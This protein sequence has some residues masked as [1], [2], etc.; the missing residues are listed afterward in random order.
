MERVPGYAIASFQQD[1]NSP[2]MLLNVNTA[3][4]IRNTRG[5]RRMKLRRRHRTRRRGHGKN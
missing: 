5:G 3:A 2:T 4:R 1:P